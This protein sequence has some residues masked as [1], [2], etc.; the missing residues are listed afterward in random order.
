LLR[1]APFVK[2][3]RRPGCVGKMQHLEGFSKF[4]ADSLA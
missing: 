4:P 3:W 2:I 1:F